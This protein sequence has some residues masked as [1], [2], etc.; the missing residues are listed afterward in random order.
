MRRFVLLLPFAFAATAAIGQALSGTQ[1]LRMDSDH[2]AIT[3]TLDGNRTRFAET[4][5][6]LEYNPANPLK[7][8]IALSLDTASIE[9]E[10]PRNA[11]DPER[12][13][14]MRIISTTDAKPGKAGMEA[15][16]VNITIRDITRPAL[17]QVS[18]KISS[19]Q[20]IT[21]HAETVMKAADFRLGQRGNIP[22]V[23]DAPFVRV[24]Q[25]SR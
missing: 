14:E 9:A 11:F 1:T 23:I 24:N 16:P 7:S 8:T 5:G 6:A 25:A 12:F 4:A 19:A 22:L 10:T 21:L 13:P 3:V 18:F 17:L 15:L 20:I 2:V